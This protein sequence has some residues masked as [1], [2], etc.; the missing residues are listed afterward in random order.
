MLKAEDECQNQKLVGIYD[1]YTRA[2]KEAA[3]LMPDGKVSLL[4]HQGV[5]LHFYLDYGERDEASVI[6]FAKI[7]ALTVK[8]EIFKDKEDGV[9]GFQMASE[10]GPSIILK[11]PS[12][13]GE[14]SAHSRVSLGPSANDPAK[15]LL[16]DFPP[17]SWHLAYRTSHDVKEW[18]YV[19][20]TPRQTQPI[21]TAFNEATESRGFA[22][23]ASIEKV[24]D[25][26]PKKPSV[27]YGFVFRADMDG[28][29]K[30]VRQTFETGSEHAI[31]QLALDFIN[32]MDDVNDWQQ[33]VIPKNKIIVFPWAG[34]CCNMVAYPVDDHDMNDIGLVKKRLSDFPTRMIRAWNEHLVAKNRQERMNKWTY[35]MASGIIK[36]FSVFVDHVPYRLMVG[37]PVGISQEGVN[38][39]GADSGDLIMH[40]DDVNEMEDYAKASFSVFNAA[41][42]YRRQSQASRD[43][44]VIAQVSLSASEPSYHGFSTPK[45]KPYFPTRI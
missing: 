29:T 7:L 19:D 42:G 11:M 22:K 10:F 15:K 26:P 37:W 5:L 6:A 3:A 23:N 25:N 41:K 35:G 45:S 31:K 44:A 2:A 9:I 34:D 30:R 39:D 4:E 33:S 17:A 24:P 12:A 18:A 13:S 20:C 14:I 40:R 32:F 8:N 43:K 16:G 27:Y 1:D 28:F 36:V 38:L 21:L